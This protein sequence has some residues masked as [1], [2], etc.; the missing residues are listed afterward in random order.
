M[1]NELPEGTQEWL[2]FL[3]DWDDIAMGEKIRAIRDK[4]GFIYFET[5]G[6]VRSAPPSN[7]VI[8]PGSGFTIEEATAMGTIFQRQQERKEWMTTANC[9]NSLEPTERTDLP[10][11]VVNGLVSS[12]VAQCDISIRDHEK[13]LKHLRQ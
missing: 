1:K 11:Y 10:L 2:I 8:V 6:L 3:N 4:D 7:Y 13:E 9:L 5:N 12:K